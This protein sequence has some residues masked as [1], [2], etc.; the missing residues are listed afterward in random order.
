MK[1][2]FIDYAQQYLLSKYGNKNFANTKLAQ[3][4][5]AVIVHQNIVRV[6]VFGSFLGATNTDMVDC[7]SFYIKMLG[8][9]TLSQ[10]GINVNNKEDSDSMIF[11]FVRGLEFAREYFECS[12]T[13]QQFKEISNAIE[14][15]KENDTKKINR[16]GLVNSEK[17]F[18][19]L[20]VQYKLSISKVKN[21]VRDLFFGANLNSDKE[22]SISEFDMMYRAVEPSTYNTKDTKE[23]FSLYAKE[24]QM[25]SFKEFVSMC[26][27]KKLFTDE[28]QLKLLYFNKEEEFYKCVKAI[29]EN[30]DKISKEISARLSGNEAYVG[31]VD[32]LKHKCT[33]EGTK[34]AKSIILM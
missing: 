19:I 34:Y 29:K 1:K 4:V 9:I 15:I 23:L 5:K 14:K 6:N 18:N 32:Y 21:S 28:A 31:T 33:I 30:F 7:V 16:S 27:E 26:T 22:I 24:D 25:L 10:M 3:L 12:L 11:P 17:L 13:K 2:P 20:V 8:F